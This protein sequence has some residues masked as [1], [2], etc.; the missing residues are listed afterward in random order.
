MQE[1]FDPPR[2]EDIHLSRL[3]RSVDATQQLR[4]IIGRSIRCTRVCAGQSISTLAMTA[5]ISAGFLFRLEK[6]HN[7]P[8]LQ[9]L[10]PIAIERDTP[11]AS[12]INPK[13]C[14]ACIKPAGARSA[15]SR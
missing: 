15:R 12:L 7:I 5:G 1:A 11:I 3:L 13:P 8:S 10:H 4:K 14:G 9:T 6:G 2:Q